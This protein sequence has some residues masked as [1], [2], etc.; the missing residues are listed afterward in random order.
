MASVATPYGLRPVNLIGGTP[1]NGGVIR[2][3]PMT[4]N[5][6]TPIYNGDLVVITNGQPAAGTATPT[7]SSAGVVGVCVGVSYIDPV[8]RQQ[9]FAQFLP[10]NA[11]T[12]GYTNI[13]IR[14]CDDPNQLYQIQASGSVTRATGLGK[15]VAI[16]NFGGSTINGN[17]TV[18]AAVGTLATTN[19]L[20]FRIV[21]F[22]EG[23]LSQ[24]GDAFTDL[25]VK[26]NV[27][28]HAY[29]QATGS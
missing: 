7:T 27:G 20:G 26:F 2:E 21:D 16:D 3:F 12:G 11:V 19:T 25:I 13:R 10:A 9:Q 5:S 23:P 8:L 1:F 28:V 15:N 29:T 4:T 14:V 18:R 6:A 22:V 17:S 24:P